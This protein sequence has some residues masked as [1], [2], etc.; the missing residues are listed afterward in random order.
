MGLTH[1]TTHVS[2]ALAR[3][4]QQY[5]STT[6]LPGLLT[7]I[8]GPI[9]EI[10]DA[11]FSLTTGRLTLNTASTYGQQLDYLGELVGVA[12]QYAESDA[13][14]LIDILTKISE[15]SSRSTPEFII[16]LYALLLSSYGYS[17]PYAIR[18]FELQPATVT[19]YSA[20]QLPAAILVTVKAIVLS[21]LGGG[22][23]LDQLGS[24]SGTNPFILGSTT[25]TWVTNGLG[26]VNNPSQGAYLG[27]LLGA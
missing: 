7:A 23:N 9:Q 3:L 22:I 16:S 4:L 2:D 10:E 27:T 6:N 17:G 8:L 25:A 1:D 24:V 18:L 13:N 19:L 12:R 5:S 20:V 21:L 14:Y 26:S 15:N 11:L